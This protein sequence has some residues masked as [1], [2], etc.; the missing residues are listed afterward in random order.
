MRTR[1]RILVHLVLVLTLLILVPSASAASSHEIVRETVTWT[2]P[3]GQC[4]S[5]PAGISVSG[6]GER[7]EV[8]NT[9]LN[10]DGSSQILINDLVTGTA[11][12]SSGGTYR[13]VY[14]NHSTQD[15]PSGSGPIHVNMVDSFVL[16]GNGSVGH[17]SVG[18]NWR[19]SYSPPAEIWPPSDNFQ[20]VSTRGDPFLCDPI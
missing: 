6:T 13:F 5:L 18:F 4:A 7:L 15:V 19:W 3:A 8:I 17:M 10:A 20:Q 14:H 1:R 12:D 2:L 16:N 9:K 11:V